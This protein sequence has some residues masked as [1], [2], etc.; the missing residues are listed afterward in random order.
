MLDNSPVRMEGLAS[1]CEKGLCQQI[2]VLSRHYPVASEGF[3]VGF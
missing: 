3:F 2:V 1:L